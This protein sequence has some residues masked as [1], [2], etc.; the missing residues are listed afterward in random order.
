MARA[1]RDDTFR[2]MCRAACLALVCLMATRATASPRTDPTLG[3]AVFTG[4]TEDHPT[5]IEVNPAALGLGLHNEFYSA[6]L[7]AIDQFSIAH[8]G[9]TTTDNVTDATL[10]PG[11]TFA[12]I[13]HTGT[14]G[15]ITLAGQLRTAP[16][17][18]FLE[19][20]DALRYSI[21][22]GYQRTFAADVAASF[23]ITNRWYFGIGLSFQTS[24]LRLRYARDTALEAGRDPT[25]GIDSDC[26]GAPC[27]IENPAASEVYD[28]DV[29]T[30][31]FSASNVIGATL[32]TLVKLP[33]DIWLGAGYHL[34]PGLA[35][36]NTLVGT[37]SVERA[38]RDGGDT[39][40]GASTVYLSQPATWDVELRT[41][42]P[43]DL[44]LHVGYHGEHLSRMSTYDVR[45]FGSTFSGAGIPEWMPRARGFHSTH[46]IWAGAE[47]IELG[48]IARFGGRIGYETST[49]PDER[50]TAWTIQPASVTLDGGVQLVLF[51][52]GPSHN[53]LLAQLSYGVQYF[54]TVHVDNSEFDPG[55]R[56]ACYD[57]G[58]DYSTPACNETRKGYGIPTANGDYSR[59]EHAIRFG[60][61]YELK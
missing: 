1:Y 31:F 10:S 7:A 12:G 58:F 32:G 51:D 38:P 14:D 42:I 47:Q 27:G 3:R 18:R 6:V 22:G 33:R 45:A 25:R 41:R 30:G 4:A 34:P 2:A 28:V 16:A 44:D 15:K 48:Q 39:I 21:L 57:S 36:Q 53:R 17:E 5:S 11:G 40:T 35:V 55:S 9:V 50:T 13:W 26:D 20:H 52:Q 56:L 19:S 59:I 37:M 49:I 46:A 43:F 23:R 61:R 29:S 24:W 8:R 60:L 54:P